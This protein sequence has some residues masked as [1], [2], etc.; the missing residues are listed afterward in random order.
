[1]QF[2]TL[3][4]LEILRIANLRIP[5]LNSFFYNNCQLFNDLPVLISEKPIQMVGLTP[6]PHSVKIPFF[7]FLDPLFIVLSGVD[8]L[9]GQTQDFLQEG[10]HP[11]CFFA[12]LENSV[13]LKKIWSCG[14]P[15]G[16]VTNICN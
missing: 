12:F 16:S 6:L 2:V 8:Y 13:K 11:V 1:M 14:P 10:R 4:K 9:K 15:T 5:I 7:P 3:K